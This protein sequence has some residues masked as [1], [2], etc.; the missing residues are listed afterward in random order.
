MKNQKKEIFDL[1]MADVD[2]EIG[3]MLEE[4]DYENFGDLMGD[5]YKWFI[6]HADKS[7]VMNIFE[8]SKSER[9]TA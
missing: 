5:I 3:N 6:S 4:L 8:V 7:K 2:E 9:C 1:Y